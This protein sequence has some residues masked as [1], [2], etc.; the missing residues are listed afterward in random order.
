MNVKSHPNF[1]TKLGGRSL[2]IDTCKENYTAIDIGTNIGSTL[3]NLAKKTSQGGG[4]VIGFEPD[5]LNYSKCLK[6]VELNSFNNIE[7]SN[8][9][10]GSEKKRVF[11]AVNSPSNRGGN[12]VIPESDSNLQQEKEAI[13]ITTLDDFIKE[14]ETKKVDLIKIDVEGYEHEVIKG[15]KGILAKHPPILFIEIDDENLKKQS[16]SASMLISDLEAM[17]YSIMRADTG[18]HI[19]SEYNFEKCHFDI[20]CKRS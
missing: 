17:G 4:T 2:L 14:R 11:L 9:G 5:K 16:T 19:T 18:E 15:A 20:L 7:V 13:D 12:R 1:G 8:L 6:N 3:L 10:L